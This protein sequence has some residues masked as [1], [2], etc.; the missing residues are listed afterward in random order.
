ML[1]LV[2]GRT[3]QIGVF[4]EDVLT[5]LSRPQKML[6]SRWL[7]DDNGCKLFEAI[8]QLEE[9]YP[10]R[11][12]T[13]ILKLHAREIADLCGRD[14]TLLE[15]GVGA[16]IKTEI[17]L[18]AFEAPC[19][20][21]PIDI[22]ADF[23]QQTAARI[24]R[25]FPHLQV[26]CLNADF[27]RDFGIH[28]KLPRKNRVAFFPGST[29]GN[30]NDS[31]ALSFFQR[32]RRHVGPRGTAIIGA[33][34]K[35]DIS[36][37]LAAYDD[38]QGITAAFNLNLLARANRE[39]GA[40]FALNRFIHEVRWN[41]TESAI[42]MHL[43]SSVKQVVTIDGRSFAFAAG[44]TIHT[45]SSRKYSLNSFSQLAGR[46]GWHVAALWTDPQKH[47]AVFALKT[48]S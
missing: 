12:E 39:L 4:R 21:V 20:Y 48:A 35:K 29:I 3:L 37:L 27:T 33:D 23:L 8:T 1:E 26:C 19:L 18:H 25:R 46:G 22:A 2:D 13:A 32:V 15:Y 5:G 43:V 41:E 30:L 6:P 36:T 16:G 17:L 10:T 28:A 40:D 44:E 7:Y 47:F 11:T 38:P 9:Y 42:E 34:L 24:G 31:E 14:A 45:A